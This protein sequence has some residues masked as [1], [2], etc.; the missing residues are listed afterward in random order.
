MHSTLSQKFN[1]FWIFRTNPTASIVTS[2][3]EIKVLEDAQSVFSEHTMS[4]G[5]KIPLFKTVTFTLPKHQIN[6]TG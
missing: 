3:F 5:K 2:S 4:L 6:G 1:F